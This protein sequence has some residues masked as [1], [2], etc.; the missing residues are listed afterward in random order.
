MPPCLERY[1]QPLTAQPGFFSPEYCELPPCTALRPYI[2]C[3]WGTQGFDRPLSQAQ[4]KGRLVTPDVCMDVILSFNFTR[5]KARD[6]FCGI[7][8]HACFSSAAF[9]A[10]RTC[11][12]GIRFYAWSAAL[13]S[14]E[15]M[16]GALN[17]RQESG[18]YFS[19]LGQALIPMLLHTET[20][21][22]RARIA[23]DYL[24]SRLRPA[25][26]NADVMNAIYAMVRGGGRLGIRE[27][28]ARH[29]VGERRLERLF[30]T[31]VGVPPK[32]MSDLIRYQLLWRELV[33]GPRESMVQL[34][35]KYGY[36]DQAH[37]INDFKRYHTMTPAE[38]LRFAKKR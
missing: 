38:A 16:H 34:A 22:Q 31:C 10:G 36:F 33:W 25:R 2:R 17:A 28:A 7:D 35:L 13:F 6:V 32:K 19:G 27:L 15:D 23:Q 14:D 20:L 29:A 12:F 37:L 8:D 9:L 18:A 11:T 3:F 5:N 26:E 4:P 21:A 24:L 1:F 30:K